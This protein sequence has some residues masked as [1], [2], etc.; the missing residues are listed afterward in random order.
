L[1]PAELRAGRLKL[2][3]TQSEAGHLF[4]A[5]LRTWQDWEA[6]FRTPHGST[7]LLIELACKRPEVVQWLQ[8]KLLGLQEGC[9]NP[10]RRAKKALSVPSPSPGRGSC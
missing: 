2:G 7:L 9:E 1:T 3:L 6:G 5:T 4:G 10:Q 8:E